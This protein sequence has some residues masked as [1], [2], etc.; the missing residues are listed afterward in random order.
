MW[1]HI[2]D[3]S[4]PL[5]GKDNTWVLWAICATGAAA[6]IYLEQRYKWA[7]KMTGAIIALIFA[8][9]LSN[10]GIIPMDAP[11]WDVVWGFVVPLSI[12]LLL[13]Q[14]DMRKI[15]KDSGRILI[16]FLI[17]SVGTACGSL[18]ALTRRS[19][20]LFRNWEDLPEYLPELTS[21]V[22]LTSQPSA[23]HS[24]YPER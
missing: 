1:G 12:P 9:V 20:N 22:L 10:F 21:A 2:F 24:T 16:I 19:T 7:A 14:C 13:L 4:N 17:G 23:P 5:V 8:I 11:V 15:G 6:A 18:L 3:L